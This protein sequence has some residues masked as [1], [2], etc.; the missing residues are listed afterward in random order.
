[1]FPLMFLFPFLKAFLI[2][3]RVANLWYHDAQ[4]QH[5]YKNDITSESRIF[6]L[7]NF[8]CFCFHDPYL[9]FFARSTLFD[10]THPCEDVD[11]LLSL[12]WT[13]APCASGT[14]ACP[15][16]AG[17]G[18]CSASADTHLLADFLPQM[19]ESGSSRSHAGSNVSAGARGSRRNDFLHRVLTS[20]MWLSAF[21]RWPSQH[22]TLHS[23]HLLL[24]PSHGVGRPRS[25]APPPGA[26]LQHA[27]TSMH[28]SSG[29]QTGG[30]VLAISG[31]WG[32]WEAWFSRLPVLVLWVLL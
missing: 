12:W 23:V 30:E 4:I 27:A 3:H 16:Q 5:H 31:R 6:L 26:P 14:A 10:T 25:S 19:T 8:L 2:F 24:F 1:M 21:S 9:R 18:G 15:S 28:V 32:S 22:C 11:A 7:N 20:H 17:E 13:P 29:L